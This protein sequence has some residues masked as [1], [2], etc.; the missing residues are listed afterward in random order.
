M[1]TIKNWLG[2]HWVGAWIVASISFAIIIHIL[3]SIEADTKYLEARWSA[4]D[5]LSYIGTVTL[6]FLALWQ[7]K[8]M[9]EN[10]DKTQARLEKISIH[11]NEISIINRIVEY[12]AERI[13]QLKKHMDIFSELCTPP[14]IAKALSKDGIHN[15]PSIMGLSDLES[16]IH[17][18]FFAV[19]RLL[20]EDQTV[21]HNDDHPLKKALT[22]LYIETE[23]TI[24]KY[25]DGDIQ[26]D[27]IQLITKNAKLLSKLGDNFIQEKERYISNEE[28]KYRKLLLK[29]MTLD[30]IRNLYPL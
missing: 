27:N 23:S 2:R 22:T 18:S 15:I 7:N 12:Q 9:Q 10:N 19:G 25:R 26:L 16:Q 21:K 3:F 17:S 11:A 5:L 14:T 29:D 6:G 1:N 24:K 13:R 20:R 4:G 28:A 8:K 30:E